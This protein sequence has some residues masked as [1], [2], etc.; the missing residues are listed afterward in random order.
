VSG[1]T[2]APRRAADNRLTGSKTGLELRLTEPGGHLIRDYIEGAPALAPF[3]AGHPTD[4]ES[5]RRK[6]AAVSSRMAGRDRQRVREAYRPTTSAAADKLEQVLSGT[7]LAVTTG[8]QAGLFGGP[9][10]TVFKIISAVRL[11]EALEARLERPVLAVFWVGSH[12]HDWIEVNHAHTVDSDGTLHRLELEGDAEPAVAMFDRMLGPSIERTVAELVALLP[13]SAFS[14]ALVDLVRSSYRP[15]QTMASAFA[16]L[17]Y[18]LLRDFDVALFDPA[19]SSVWPVSGPVIEREI[20]NAKAHT[21]L[22]E[23]TADRLIRAGYTAQ[24]AIAADA[25][26]AFLHDEN[27]RDRLMLENG[28]WALRRTKRTLG[29]AELHRLIREAPDRFTPNVLL[30]PI[31]ESTLIPTIAYVGGPAEVSYFAQIGCLFDAH[32]IEPP[33]VVPRHGVTIVEARVRRVLDKF[34][35]E[36]N[37]FARPFHEVATRVVRE[38]LPET[39]TDPVENLRTTTETEFETLIEGA[40]AVDPTLR[41]WAAGIRNRILGEIR[42]ADRKITS[43]LRKRSR[44]EL[45]QLRKAA[46]NLYP[47]GSPQE[48]VVSVVPLIARYG[49]GLLQDIAEI[50]EHRLDGRIAGWTGVECGSTAPTGDLHAGTAQE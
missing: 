35:L 21:R 9:L 40:A 24:V 39:V 5:F 30:R 36:P 43:H 48:R 27:G 50:M 3:Y 13:D 38:S 46:I 29:D 25:A 12:D 17:L 32:G 28:G 2:T 19:H 23:S 10:Y 31:V 1:A 7:G 41:D 15:E 44:I 42:D 22:L 4:P 49:P 45:E 16:D 33:V 34:S 26:N 47:G 20:T 6:A 37:D 11:A 14:P 18:G 8:Q